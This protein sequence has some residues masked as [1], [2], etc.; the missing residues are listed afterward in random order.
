MRNSN[1]IM[2]GLLAFVGVALIAIGVTSIAT[3]GSKPEKTVYSAET[4]NVFMKSCTRMESEQVCGCALGRLQ[5]KYG[6]SEYLKYV[7]CISVPSDRIMSPPI[8]ESVRR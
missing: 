5:Q 8:L 3:Q 7:L 4:K 1:N 6:E 2:L